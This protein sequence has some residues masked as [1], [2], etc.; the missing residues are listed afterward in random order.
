MKHISSHHTQVAFSNQTKL[1]HLYQSTEYDNGETLASSG[2][3]TRPVFTS[4]PSLSINTLPR[5]HWR[6]KAPSKP[7]QLQPLQNFAP[8]AQSGHAQRVQSMRT[9]VIPSAAINVCWNPQLVSPPVFPRRNGYIEITA[10]CGNF[11]L[12]LLQV[13]K[14]RLH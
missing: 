1:H 11:V 8:L 9:K 5:P 6:S 14:K 12:P 10:S 2:L 7:H 3:G 4:N 13:P